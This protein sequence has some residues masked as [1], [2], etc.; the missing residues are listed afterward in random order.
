V[1]Q[2]VGTSTAKADETLSE[3]LALWPS[4]EPEIRARLLSLARDFSKQER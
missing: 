2:Q 3:L 4:L 1:G